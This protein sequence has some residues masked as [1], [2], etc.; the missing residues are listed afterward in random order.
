MNWNEAPDL[1][2]ASERLSE[3]V[4]ALLRR[5]EA[6]AG[7]ARLVRF[8]QPCAAADLPAWLNGQSSEIK[9]YWSGRDNGETV[10][11]VGTAWT[12]REESGHSLAPAITQINE[13]LAASDSGVRVLGGMRFDGGRESAPAW[14]AFR[15]LHFTVPR[16]ELRRNQGRCTLACNVLLPDDATGSSTT[17]FV[18]EAI[19][20][21]GQRPDTLPSFDVEILERRDR[22]DATSWTVAVT[23]C[24]D[25]FAREEAEKVVLARQTDFRLAHAANPLGLLKA[26]QDA[27]PSSYHFYFQPQPGVAFIGASPERLYRRAEGRLETEALAGTR[28]RGTTDDE[29]ARLGQDLL[30]NDKEQREH[31]H[32]ARSIRTVL[33]KLCDD[34]SQDTVDVMQLGHCQHLLTRFRGSLREG[35]GD[36]ELLTRLHPTPAVGGVPRD[37][38]VRRIRELERFDRGWYTGP[39]GWI[40]RDAAEFAVAIRSALV[41]NERVSVYT[42]AG[43]VPGSEPDEEWLELENKLTDFRSVLD[44]ATAASGPVER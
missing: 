17:A 27:T 34:V 40:G 16:L 7:S 23:A 43:I 9:W 3:A 39:I 35:C 5:D 37:I 33:K 10:A 19:A 11:A 26:L 15:A 28:P 12:I 25:A 42:G 24:L 18:R 8:E 14:Q 41:H 44:G 29:D 6:H 32:V 30:T 21:A 31:D 38:A 22:P 36:A 20:D 1:R 13:L 4:E 2:E